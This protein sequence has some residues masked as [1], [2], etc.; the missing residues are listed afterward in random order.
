MKLK[1]DHRTWNHKEIVRKGIIKNWS[2]AKMK[3]RNN[4]D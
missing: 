1:K 3:Y 2:S 4:S